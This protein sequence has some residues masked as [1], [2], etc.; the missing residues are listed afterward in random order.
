MAK[1]QYV[2]GETLSVVD[3]KLFCLAL[4]VSFKFLFTNNNAIK[5][6]ITSYS[7]FRLSDGGVKIYSYSLF[8]IGLSQPSDKN[9][10]P[11][12]RLIFHHVIISG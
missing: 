4:A 3:Q 12:V 9:L 1:L 2:E 7:K 11:A 5:N 8:I 10:S 6:E